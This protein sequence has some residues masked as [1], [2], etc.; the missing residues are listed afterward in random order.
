MCY[1]ITAD[2]LDPIFLCQASEYHTC[3]NSFIPH[4][5]PVIQSYRDRY[6]GMRIQ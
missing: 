2:I 4:N 6:W 1:K 5:T 3:I